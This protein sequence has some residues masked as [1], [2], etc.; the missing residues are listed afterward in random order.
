MRVFL[1]KDR[2][3]EN[4]TCVI[5]GLT[6][7]SFPARWFRLPEGNPGA[8]EAVATDFHFHDVKYA[9]LLRSWENSQIAVPD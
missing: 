8:R 5:S 2:L 1:K 7:P 4:K 3:Y 9:M 6:M